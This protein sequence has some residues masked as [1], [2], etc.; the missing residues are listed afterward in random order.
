MFVA[1]SDRELDE[2]EE[3]EQY[4]DNDQYEEEEEE[5]AYKDENNE[6]EDPQLTKDQLEYLERRQ[7][8][9]EIVRQKMK[10][11]NDLVLVSAKEKKSSSRDSF[12]S[13]FGPSQPVVAK[14]VIEERRGMLDL[15]HITISGS[16]AASQQ[17]N[18]NVHSMANAHRRST[19]SRPPPKPVDKV[20]WSKRTCLQRYVNFTLKRI[21]LCLQTKLKTQKLKEARDYSF[22][23]SG[24]AE[25][26]APAKDPI[27]QPKVLPTF[28]AWSSQV[29]ANR[30]PSLSK[31]AN[32]LRA[33]H[34]NQETVSAGRL[35]L[36]FG[37]EKGAPASNLKSSGG[38]RKIPAS[39]SGNGEPR[40]PPAG[41]AGNGGHRKL[42][43]CNAGNGEPR[44]IATGNGEPGKLPAGNAGNGEPRKIAA[45]NGEPGKLPAGNA[46]YGELR[47]LPAGNARKGEPGKLPAGNGGN[48]LGRPIGTKVPGQKLRGAT[49]DHRKAISATN[50]HK[51]SVSAPKTPLPKQQVVVQKQYIEQKRLSMQLI[52]KQ[53]GNPQKQL[54][55]WPTST[56]RPKKRPADEHSDDEGSGGD[57][58][59]LIRQMFRYDPNRYRGMDEDD[60]DME[61]DFRRIQAEERPSARIAKEEDERELALIEEE[62]RRERERKEAKRRK[63]MSSRR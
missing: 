53:N 18:K 25:F 45:G 30:K 33:V 59:S 56:K 39:I 10:K 4:K 5:A 23:L 11:E 54:P 29:T 9:K 13:F 61:V 16:K 55:S 41:N 2:Y 48:G 58:R 36:H 52:G 40:K 63:L 14:R 60:S 6:E 26:P 17:Q 37:A 42:P 32:A 24:D 21:A 28:D 43:A 51:P 3:D 15:H 35:P 20:W 50:K 62:E 46:G 7:K 19:E 1:E 22:L 49:L 34:G 57:Y 12:G 8:L 47:K 44:K 27:P 31:P 38:T